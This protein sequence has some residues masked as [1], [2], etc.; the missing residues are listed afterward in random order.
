MKLKPEIR[1][2]KQLAE[3]VR[4]SRHDSRFFT[5]NTMNFFG[6][7]FANYE[8]TGPLPIQSGGETVFVYKLSR[9]RAVK[10]GLKHDTFFHADFF[11]RV[12]QDD[13][14]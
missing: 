5:K 2:A 13:V 3:H 7:S 1:T 4:N 10:H 8:V 14:E 6:D 12:F 11:N 9:K